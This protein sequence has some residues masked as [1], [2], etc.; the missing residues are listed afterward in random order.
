M[1][2]TCPSK[3]NTCIKVVSNC[4]TCGIHKLFTHKHLISRTYTNKR[5]REICAI[6][7]LL[8]RHYFIPLIWRIVGNKI[9]STVCQIELTAVPK[10]DFT[11]VPLRPHNRLIFHPGYLGSCPYSCSRDNL[12]DVDI[13]L[14]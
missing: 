11:P 5:D 9:N 4:I 6:E 2:K 3:V 10:A 12:R 1:P 14:F 13:S 7:S 8:L